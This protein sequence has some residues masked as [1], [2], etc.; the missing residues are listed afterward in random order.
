MA[1]GSQRLGDC[2]NI[3]QG[4]GENVFPM[5]G[6]YKN[7]KKSRNDSS[8]RLQSL[9]IFIFPYKPS[10]EKREQRRGGHRLV[11]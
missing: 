2:V 4:G 3:E 7:E 6:L 1:V 8:S 5:V 9:K 10:G 11:Y